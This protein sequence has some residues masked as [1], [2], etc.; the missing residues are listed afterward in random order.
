MVSR[1][2]NLEQLRLE[3][4]LL[5]IGA[6]EHILGFLAATEFALSELLQ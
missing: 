4:M 1:G 3:V 5:G 6:A 2:T